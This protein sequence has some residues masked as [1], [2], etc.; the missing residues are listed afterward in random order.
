MN[1]NMISE[2]TEETSSPR[3]GTYNERSQHR[4]LKFFFEPD[5]SY[6]EI[7]V[8]TYIADVCKN[9]HIYEIQTSGFGN[10]TSKLGVF[11]L[12]HTVSVVYP[13]AISK[14]IVWSDPESGDVIEG[15]HVV[16]RGVRFKLLAELLHIYSFISN[17]KFSLIL[18]ETDVTDIRLLDG[19]G[20]D[21]KIKATK[22]DRILG[23]VVSQ[24]VLSSVNDIKE[25]S[26]LVSGEEYTRDGL[27]RKFMLK[28][29]NL[30]A[31]IKALSL[32]EIIEPCRK[33]GKRI[34]YRVR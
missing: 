1:V 32:L 9:G 27:G 22:L 23:S 2:E 5:P 33:E 24:T 12:D 26:E 14:R 19:R 7:P 6:H 34:F 3:I 4:A 29:R 11:L 31:A 16:K 28:N 30:S 17:D 20:K 21:K 18:C 13:A 25:F 10:L 15:R 8:H